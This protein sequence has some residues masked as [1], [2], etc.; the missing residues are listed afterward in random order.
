M[1]AGAAAGGHC[2]G[3]GTRNGGRNLFN[4]SIAAGGFNFKYVSRVN[5]MCIFKTIESL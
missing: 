4:P 1:E 5:N 3:S 2:G